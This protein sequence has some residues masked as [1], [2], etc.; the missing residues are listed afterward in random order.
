MEGGGGVLCREGKNK[1][2]KMSRVTLMIAA[3]MR[4]RFTPSSKKARRL[5]IK[6]IRHE[7][8]TILPRNGPKRADQAFARNP[9]ANL[10]A[11]T[12]PLIHWLPK[13]S[14]PVA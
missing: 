1:A 8:Q 5:S 6:M 10:C 14:A 4:L 3:R 12:G 7:S 11:E 13:D 2:P 9:K